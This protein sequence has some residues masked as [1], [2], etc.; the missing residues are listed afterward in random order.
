ML[1][2]FLKIRVLCLKIS[3]TDNVAACLFESMADDHMVQ[4]LLELIFKSFTLTV[5]RILIDHLPDSKFHSINDP[6][7]IE[8]T[9]S[10]P[11]TNVVSE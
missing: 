1:N 10:V 3:E 6:K 4:E 2:V 8:E 7:M 5:Q 11:K 9:K